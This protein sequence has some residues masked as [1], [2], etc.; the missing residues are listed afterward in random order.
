MKV[1]PKNRMIRIFE[2]YITIYKMK[3][4]AIIDKVIL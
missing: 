1:L 2:E 3:A 4:F